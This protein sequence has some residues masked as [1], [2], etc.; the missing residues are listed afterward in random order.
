M[1]P[2]AAEMCGVNSRGAAAFCPPSAARPK[3]TILSPIPNLAVSVRQCLIALVA[4]AAD[5]DLDDAVSK[6]ISVYLARVGTSYEAK[7][8]LV[9]AVQASPDIPHQTTILEV[10]AKAMPLNPP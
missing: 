2:W 4:I 8:E 1:T 9:K 10:M 6:E 3:G 7:L 5:A